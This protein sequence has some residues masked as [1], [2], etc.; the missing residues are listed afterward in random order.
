[1]RYFKKTVFIF[2]ALAT[3][4][5]CKK[6]DLASSKLFQAETIKATKNS[7]KSIQDKFSL[8]N[9]IILENNENSMFSAIDKV[10]FK[11]DKIFI[12][13]NT[14]LHTVLIFDMNGKFIQKIGN[15]G[16]GPGEVSMLCDFDVDDNG[17]TYLY[18]RQQK[19]ILKY[20][21][22]G[23][24]ISEYKLPFRADAF[25][26]LNNGYIFSVL[27]ANDIGKRHP[28]VLVTDTLFSIKKMYFSY[29]DKFLDNKGN[30][31]IFTEYSGGLL[32]NK[33][34]ND[35]VF[36][37]DFDGNLTRSF[38]FDFGQ[39]MLPDEYKN[40][41]VKYVGEKEKRFRYM[42]RAPIFISNY[43]VGNIFSGATKAYF[44]CDL[45]NKEIQF[46]EFSVNNFTHL[47]LGVPIYTLDDS[48]VVSYIDYEMYSASRDSDI[49]SDNEKKH[50]ERGGVILSFFKI[51]I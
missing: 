12:M 19:K 35:T 6:K 39:Y 7:I 17:N 1:M 4:T 5:L 47:E 37:F 30:K 22:K 50:L 21:P 9:Y 46:K 32:Y 33:P 25:S 34:V 31:N 49:F 48:I 29:D 23:S 18:N 40:D 26:L 13:D 51:P 42:Y 10:R 45:S 8:V 36:L 3:F 11:N 44:Q 28:K 38:F 43:L 16:K 14:S 24:F 41:Y 2:I 15:Q 27:K 20:D